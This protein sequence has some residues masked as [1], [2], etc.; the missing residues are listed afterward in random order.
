MRRLRVEKRI[1]QKELADA[2]GVDLATINQIENIDRNVDRDPRISSLSAIAHALRVML[3]DMFQSTTGDSV[4][5]GAYLTFSEWFWHELDNEL[6]VLGSKELYSEE[7]KL[8]RAFD[9][10]L[11]MA[12]PARDFTDEEKERI[13]NDR[14]FYFR[15]SHIG[16]GAL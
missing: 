14:Q 4:E 10:F 11:V 12:K 1:T 3:A 13:W 15:S 8:R 2:S 5:F 7:Q 16:D 9:G 6:K